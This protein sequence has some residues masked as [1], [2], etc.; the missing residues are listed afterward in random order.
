MMGARASTSPCVFFRVDGA[1]ASSSLDAAALDA[2]AQRLGNES[3]R[4]L[5]IMAASSD[6]LEAALLRGVLTGEYPN[7]AFLAHRETLVS[8]DALLS[9]DTNLFVTSVALAA[10]EAGVSCGLHAPE[11][12]APE[13]SVAPGAPDS[14]VRRV[15]IERLL[16]VLWP[17]LARA[18]VASVAHAL[19]PEQRLDAVT[20][21]RALATIHHVRRSS[22]RAPATG[23][24][25]AVL[26][27]ALAPVRRALTK[28]AVEA[29]AEEDPA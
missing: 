6:S 20:A 21:A 2:A 10:L 1:S 27:R 25:L 9:N 8:L 29:I 7:G 26:D 28:H 4:L 13:A 14:R 22:P 17:E 16:S 24:Q 12:P 15:L 11:M 5:F 19:T 3:T 18:H 23:E